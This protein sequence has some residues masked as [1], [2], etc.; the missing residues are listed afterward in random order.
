MDRQL[1]LARVTAFLQRF[2][3]IDLPGHFVPQGRH[4]GRLLSKGL[5]VRPGLR[6]VVI[7]A[8]DQ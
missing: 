1:T 2:K 8:A 6:G 3:P 5:A 7:G 4:V